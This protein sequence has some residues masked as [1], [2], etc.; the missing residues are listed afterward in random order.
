MKVIPDVRY[1]S[2]EKFPE[3]APKKTTSDIN[4]LFTKYSPSTSPSNTETSESSVSSNFFDYLT[5]KSKSD[6]PQ[7]GGGSCSSSN[8]SSE[9]ASSDTSVTSDTDSEAY[10]GVVSYDT[11]G[12]NYKSDE[13]EIDSD[14]ESDKVKS[15]VKSDESTQFSDDTTDE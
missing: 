15:D 11:D 5:K 9:T 1:L 10:S 8:Y 2:P 7:S 6:W 12:E 13:N 4:D 3:V 14:S